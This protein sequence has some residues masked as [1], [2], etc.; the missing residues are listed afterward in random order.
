MHN[1]MSFCNTSIRW[2]IIIITTV[3][4]MGILILWLYCWQNQLYVW[5]SNLRQMHS[6]FLVICMQLPELWQGY[7]SL[8]L[9]LEVICTPLYWPFGCRWSQFGADNSWA[10]LIPCFPKCFCKI[11]S[12]FCWPCFKTCSRSTLINTCIAFPR[13]RI[14]MINSHGIHWHQVMTTW[15]Q[16]WVATVGPIVG[17]FLAKSLF[18]PVKW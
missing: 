9:N 6:P 2:I 8:I 3:W 13:Y 11:L 4:S 10:M 16:V 17:D 1:C 7:P 14:D 15:M 5:L 18:W 12:A